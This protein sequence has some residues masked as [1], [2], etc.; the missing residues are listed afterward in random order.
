MAAQ[1]DIEDNEFVKEIMRSIG[2]A[3]FKM[4]AIH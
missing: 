2:R 4:A 1:I 3:N